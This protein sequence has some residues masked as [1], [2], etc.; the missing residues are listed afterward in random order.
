MNQVFEQLLKAN[1]VTA[2][3][4]AQATGLSYPTLSNWRNG[5]TKDPQDETLQKI[6]DFFNV[7]LEFLKG[8]VKS[9]EC[10][11]CH[12][13]YNPCRPKSM[14][15]HNSFHK[16]FM[17]VQKHYGIIIPSRED[18]EKRR[19]NAFS[20][21]RDIKYDKFRRISAFATYS[22]CNFVC[23]LYDTDFPT[24]IDM[25]EYARLQAEALRPDA[26]ISL[27]L[28]NAIRK[29]YGLA[30]YV[31]DLKADITDWEYAM[32]LRYRELPKDSKE[33]VHRMFGMGGKT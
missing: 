28:C 33:L 19:A 14:T 4:V 29:E 3:Y 1:S 16:H 6:A 15:A 17:E 10:P 26:S 5:K 27:D 31:E 24:N 22:A 12:Y 21:L 9:I 2:Y 23:F 30:E 7:P 25:E 8:E 13:Q 11:D 18:A 20:I 32:V